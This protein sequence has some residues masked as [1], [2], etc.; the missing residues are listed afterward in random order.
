MI[1]VPWQNLSNFASVV[2]EKFPVIVFLYI[3]LMVCMYE[4][5]EGRKQAYNQLSK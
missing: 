5:I 1:N 4:S 2:L 3:E